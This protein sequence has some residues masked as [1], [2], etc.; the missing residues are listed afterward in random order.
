M[1]GTYLDVLG[2]LFKVGLQVRDHIKSQN[3]DL[4]NMSILL[5][6]IVLVK[7]SCTAGDN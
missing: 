7:G 4:P 3:K 5:Q 1:L 2:T 6:V